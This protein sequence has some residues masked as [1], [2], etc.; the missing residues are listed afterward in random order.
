MFHHQQQHG[1][2][3]PSNPSSF[4]A[5]PGNVF[6]NSM[7]GQQGSAGVLSGMEQFQQLPGFPN[8]IEQCVRQMLAENA[9][10]Q[11]ISQMASMQQQQQQPGVPFTVNPSSSLYNQTQNKA[12][13]PTP[14]PTRAPNQFGNQNIAPSMGA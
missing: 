13:L 1:M 14:Q 7:I 8:I 4:P 9:Q 11:M 12:N 2:L 3:M 10:L 5:S 6:N